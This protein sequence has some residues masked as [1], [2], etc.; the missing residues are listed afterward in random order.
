MENYALW[1]LKNALRDEVT[2]R[3]Q[4]CEVLD[5]NEPRHLINSA[6]SIDAFS[7]SLKLADSRIPQ[8]LDAISRVESENGQPTIELQKQLKTETE[9]RK[10]WEIEYY[11]LRDHLRKV[12]ESHEGSI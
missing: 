5:G 8:L 7:E 12:I 1:L 6:D 4:A 3:Q 9:L 2:F 10:R 11:E